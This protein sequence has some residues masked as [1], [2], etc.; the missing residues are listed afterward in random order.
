MKRKHLIPIALLTAIVAA[1]A[2]V[3]FGSLGNNLVY[4]ITPSELFKKGEQAYGQ[5]FRLGGV[6]RPGTIERDDAKLHLSFEVADSEQSTAAHVRVESQGAPPQM[7]RERIG[8]IVEGRYMKDGLFH[9]DRVMV[10]HSNE[11]R[12]PKPGETPQYFGSKTLQK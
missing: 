11:Y 12:P 6:V 3:S 7:F 4:Y 5:T 8:V 2:Y 9:S 1:L 10:N